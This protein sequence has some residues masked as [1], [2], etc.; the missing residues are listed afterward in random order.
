MALIK[1]LTEGLNSRNC[2]VELWYNELM[3]VTGVI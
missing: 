1:D 3:V 2:M